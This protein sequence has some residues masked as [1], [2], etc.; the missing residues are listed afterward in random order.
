[1]LLKQVNFFLLPNSKELFKGNT[2]KILAGNPNIPFG[3]F[4]F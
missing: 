2:S 1:M 3:I 4:T